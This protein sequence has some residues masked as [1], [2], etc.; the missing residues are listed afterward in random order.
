MLMVRADRLRT[1]QIKANWGD[2]V[3]WLCWPRIAGIDENRLQ[4]LVN[5]RDVDQIINSVRRTN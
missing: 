1:G 5:A 2:R 4:Q 3:L